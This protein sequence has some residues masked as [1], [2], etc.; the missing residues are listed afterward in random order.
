MH[1]GYRYN[2]LAVVVVND[3]ACHCS[4]QS[5]RDIKQCNSLDEHFACL[6]HSY[7]KL[8]FIYLD[9][10]FLFQVFNMMLSL[11]ELIKFVHMILWPL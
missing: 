1:Y 10:F 6:L 8:I 2:I 5:K 7:C 4:S 9:L 11:Q 3:N